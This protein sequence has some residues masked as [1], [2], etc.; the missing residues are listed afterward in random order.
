MAGRDRQVFGARP[1]GARSRHDAFARPLGLILALL[2]VCASW[3][4]TPPI[5]AGASTTG[6]S[7]YDLDVA[8]DPV[9]RS[10]QGAMRVEWRNTTGQP[11]D[12]LHFRLYPNASYY[13]EGETVVS[14][15]TVDGEDVD[16]EI[17]PSDPTVL[18]VGLGR[19]IEPDQ[20][21]TV[22]LAF[23]T[24]VPDMPEGSFSVLSGNARDGWW[25]ADWYPILAGREEADDVYLAPPTPFGDPTFAESATYRLDFTAP[26]GFRVLGSGVNG[27][28]VVDSLTGLVTTTIETGLGRDL[29]LSLL[30]ERPGNEPVTV[31]T[32]VAGT[33]VRVSLPPDLAIPGLGEAILDIASDALPAYEDWLGDYHEPELDIV[34]VPMAGTGGVSWHGIVWLD[35]EAIAADGTVSMEEEIRLRF[36]LTHELGHQ[37]IVGI[38]GSNN[39]DHGFMSEGLTNTLTVL[40][41]RESDGP[42]V[43]EDYLRDWIASGYRDM[44]ARGVDG[45]A[46]APVRAS[47]DIVSRARIV[48]GKSAL[49]FEAI[50]QE[51]GDP[52]FFAALASYA[53]DYRFAV[54]S[55]DDLQRA[56]EE[57]SGVDLEPLWSFWFE[58]RVTTTADVDAVLDGFGAS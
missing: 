23:E 53:V 1:D 32:T 6:Y 54:S 35:L 48:Y 25:L 38:V 42:E 50:R 13:E 17:S 15:V 30:P 45:V 3:I 12:T 7:H 34:P 9:A 44:L 40:V 26:A 52:V 55:P 11:Q 10:M 58:E 27:E 28:R 18:A 33:T 8:F 24:I 29:T 36:V 2:L 49:G 39:N 4:G 21:V 20:G 56:F 57:A 46:D 14:S 41:I 37:W 19:E 31:S 43:A 51:I 47:T 5:A 22:A 16:P